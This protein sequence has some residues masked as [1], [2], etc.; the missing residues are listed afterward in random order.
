ME[1][2][3]E[4]PFQSVVLGSTGPIVVNLPR[5]EKYGLHKLLVAPERT[6]DFKDKVRKDL[7]QAASLIEY[8]TATEPD[9]LRGAVDNLRRRGSGWTKR[10]NE[11]LRMLRALDL[12]TA[13]DLSIVEG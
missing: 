8:L 12:P 2:S 3:L 10:L 11:G 13:L 6:A 4:D 9:A 5:P 1:F 7:T